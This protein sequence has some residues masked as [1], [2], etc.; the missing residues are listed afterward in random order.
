MTILEILFQV[1]ELLSA[2]LATIFFKKY[3]KTVI[4]W[5]LPYLWY[6]VLNETLSYFLVIKR[7]LLQYELVNLYLLITVLFVL[8]LISNRVRLSKHKA[9]LHF[10]AIVFTMGVAIEWVVKGIGVS[11]Q[12]SEFIG[13][14]SVIIGTCIYGISLFINDDLSNPIKNLF[15][16]IMLGFT[17]Y[18]I[19][20]PII[21]IAIYL[22][23]DN[24]DLIISLKYLLYGTII[25]MYSIFSF[26]FIYSDKE[27]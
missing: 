7:G 11:W 8:F 18:F 10:I 22:Y 6:V 20:G 5:M 26:G 27:E 24:Y 17:T 15:T 2:I 4:K 25:L 21:F 1:A 9:I 19:A 23:S 13:A 14:L 12:F 3:N 16:Y